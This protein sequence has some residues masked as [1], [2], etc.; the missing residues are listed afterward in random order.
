M[1]EV[2]YGGDWDGARFKWQESVA[3][4][5]ERHP[6]APVHRLSG[7]DFDPA[8]AEELIYGAALFGAPI[9]VTANRL[10]GDATRLEWFRKHTT[11]FTASAATWLLF[12]ESL[13][14]DW[15]D[16][17]RA[18]GAGLREF[19]SQSKGHP[20]ST[21]FNVF[22]LTDALAAR[23]RRRLWLLYLDASRSG[24]PPE[25][26]FWKFF[27][28]IKVLLV[29]GETP[30]APTLSPFVAEKARRNSHRFSREELVE[31]SSRLVA[32]WH[33]SISGR[34]ELNL[35]LEQFILGL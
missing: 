31:L 24:L 9:L 28:Q 27:W 1:I 18:A 10:S 5:R 33:D 7:D 11:G 32:L 29:V 14:K 23:D 16:F 20:M 17:F 26:I 8:R 34:Q 4:F 30:A 12:E 6:G 13:T 15:L 21:S 3:E 2:Y 25:E 22:S 19:K 35:G